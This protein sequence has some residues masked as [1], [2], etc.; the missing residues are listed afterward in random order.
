MFIFQRRKEELKQQVLN[1]VKERETGLF[2]FQV[3]E[4]LNTKRHKTEQAINELIA[5]GKLNVKY[6]ILGGFN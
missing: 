1:L 5:E 6:G 3:V 2:Q 4:E